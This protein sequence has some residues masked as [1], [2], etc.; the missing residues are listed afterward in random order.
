MADIDKELE[1]LTDKIIV[2]Y[3]ADDIA[4]IA[5]GNNYENLE[6]SQKARLVM[7][8]CRLAQRIAA[9]QRKAESA[10]LSRIKEEG[11]KKLKN[12]DYTDAAWSHGYNDDN[13]TW[14]STIDN[15]AKEIRGEGHE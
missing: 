11:P 15:I 1:K 12:F 8:T 3:L 13:D 14:R 9:E 5:Y 10:L 6:V 4:Y 7:A 2:D